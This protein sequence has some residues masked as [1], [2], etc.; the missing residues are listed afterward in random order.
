MR[1][2]FKVMYTSILLLLLLVP[3]IYLVRSCHA[4]LL[5]YFMY[6]RLLS[7]ME[8]GAVDTVDSRFFPLKAWRVKGFDMLVILMSKHINNVSKAFYKSKTGV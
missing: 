7:V 5:T 2:Q 3:C 4:I 8:Y 6:L 1:I